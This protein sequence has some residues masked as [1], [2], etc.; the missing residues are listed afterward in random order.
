M[1]RIVDEAWNVISQ[2]YNQFVEGIQNPSLIIKSFDRQLVRN[3][4]APKRLK[5]RD[6]ILSKY[7][8]K[9]SQIGDYAAQE[10]NKINVEIDEEIKG[11]FSKAITQ[12][13]EHESEKWLKL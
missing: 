1:D 10:I 7:D 11:Q 8:N 13:I 5:E 9:I 6:S 2:V 4:Y 3:I 12:S